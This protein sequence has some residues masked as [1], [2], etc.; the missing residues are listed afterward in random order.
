MTV[1]L[2]ESIS[3]KREHVLERFSM[4]L[5]L[6]LRSYSRKLGVRVKKKIKIRSRAIRA[7]NQILNS[8]CGGLLVF[9]R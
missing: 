1:A 7:P 5:I 2:H 9:Q 3:G 8:D 6:P 4:Y